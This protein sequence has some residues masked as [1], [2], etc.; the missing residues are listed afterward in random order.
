MKLPITGDLIY[1]KRP[2]SG[3]QSDGIPGEDISFKESLVTLEPNQTALVVKSYNPH[4]LSHNKIPSKQDEL[5]QSQQEHLAKKIVSSKKP[6][7][8]QPPD[9]IVIIVLSIG[10]HIVETIYDPDYIDILSP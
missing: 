5:L 7:F 8:N 4:A 6:P 2:I 10:N 3:V 9:G 1:I